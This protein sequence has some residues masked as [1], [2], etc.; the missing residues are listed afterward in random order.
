MAGHSLYK[1]QFR[2]ALKLKRRS[3]TAAQRA[4][5]LARQVWKYPWAVEAA[6]ARQIAAWMKPMI[7][8]TKEY[9]RNQS[10]PILRGDTAHQDATPGSAFA[11]MV[12][13]LQGWAGVHFPSRENRKEG[14][15]PI[16]EM[17]LGK[18]AEA[19]KAAN[20]KQWAVSTQSLLG[21][22]F[23]TDEAWW[24]PMKDQWANMNYDLIKSL[25][26][27]YIKQVN[28]LTEKAIVN[29][30]TSGQLM[31]EITAM[32]ATITG[33]RARLI[34]RDQIGKLNGSITQARMEEVGLEMY[35]WSTSADERVRS[36]H[37]PM[38][39]L[40]CQWNDSSVYSADGGKTWIPRPSGATRSHPGYDIQC[41]CTALAY[42][43]ELVNEI[44]AEIAA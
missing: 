43:N 41:R 20:G 1:D 8:Y 22:S 44:D 3:M 15:P 10:A 31:K 27:Q 6:Y 26:N 12:D 17:G 25:S 16:V 5:P 7:D 29:G 21:V 28:D 2:Q 40:L 34:A 38:D 14:V 13:T 42:Y 35:E 36:S 4:R 33:P 19:T 18:Y 39:G 23:D 24:D 9:L 11:L 30:W 37:R 32:G